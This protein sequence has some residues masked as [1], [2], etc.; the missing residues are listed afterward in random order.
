MLLTPPMILRTE[1]FH[2]SAQ[3][4]MI[5]LF[6]SVQ[7]CEIAL[8]EKL[9][10]VSLRILVCDGTDSPGYMSSNI[11]F[12]RNLVITQENTNNINSRWQIFEIKNLILAPS[13]PKIGLILIFN[14][15]MLTV[16]EKQLNVERTNT[17]LKEKMSIF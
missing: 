16:Q 4:I 11:F 13:L 14:S 12:Y 1:N 9:C 6:I 2:A 7:I 17:T 10:I 15:M 8:K 5:V 3:M